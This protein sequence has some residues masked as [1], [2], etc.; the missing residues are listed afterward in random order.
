MNNK[1]RANI[2]A[3]FGKAIKHFREEPRGGEKKT[4]QQQLCNM[5]N[6]RHR[7]IDK[8]IRQENISRLERG[9]LVLLPAHVVKALADVC[10][11][12]DEVV[13]PYLDIMANYTKSEM[14]LEESDVLISGRG[15]L[16]TNPSNE[17]FDSY[18]GKYHCYFHSTNSRDP[19]LVQGILVINGN[20]KSITKCVAELDIYE[21]GKVIKS[22]KGQFMLNMHYRMSY[23]V[24][25]GNDKQEVCMLISNHFN[26]TKGENL[27][28]VALVL[29]TSAGSQKRPTMHRMLFT[30]KE[31]STTEKKQ[32]QSILK[33]NTDSII[34]SEKG[35]DELKKKTEQDIT[36]VKL[37]KSKL[38]YKKILECIEYIKKQSKPEL[39][40]RIDEAIIYDSDTFTEDLKL[41]SFIVSSLREYSST[42]YYNKIS[43]TVRDICLNIISKK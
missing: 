9:T 2:I 34:I 33:L 18:L 38:K 11:L 12:P 25:I 43:D 31:L 20:K 1:E 26:I 30:R 36:R 17:E 13:K 24:L 37:E 28:N 5:V 10:E 19:K 27:L 23:C 4:S 22:Y 39:Y 3:Q 35:L 7:G 32:V 6:N 29:T 14:Q 41:R 21:D 16:L 8:W 42:E 15:Q 40:Y